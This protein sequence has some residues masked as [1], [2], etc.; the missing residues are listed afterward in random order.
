MSA[1]YEA[2]SPTA[3]ARCDV[4]W[5]NPEVNMGQM[6]ERFKLGQFDIIAIRKRL[7]P[8]ASLKFVSPSATRKNMLAA[9]RRKLLRLRANVCSETAG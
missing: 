6:L 5:L 3:K 4:E 9:R 1:F 2:L 7:G 8:K